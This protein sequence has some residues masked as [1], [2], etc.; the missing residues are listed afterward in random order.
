MKSNPLRMAE[1]CKE[2]TKPRRTTNIFGVF[3]FFKESK[4]SKNKQKSKPN[5]AKSF[6]IFLLRQTKAKKQTK[7][8]NENIFGIFVFFEKEATRTKKKA[9]QWMYKEPTEHDIKMS[10]MSVYLP[11]A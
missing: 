5:K 11:Q 8:N 4:Q 6:W 2:L 1:P 3:N 9:K 10:V 7:R